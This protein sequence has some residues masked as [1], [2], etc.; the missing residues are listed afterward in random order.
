MTALSLTVPGRPLPYAR[1]RVDPRSGRHVIPK[2]QRAY[3]AHVESCMR[4]AMLQARQREP[5]MGALVMRLNVYVADLNCGDA[6]NLA[7]LQEDVAQKAGVF[8]DDVQIVDLI[9][10]R[11]V[12][13]KRPR[14]EVHV[15]QLGPIEDERI[16]PSKR[17]AT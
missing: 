14:V 12:D 15:E 2:A 8:V 6:S 4:A 17:R 13:R 7:K 9:I 16:P 5:M 11:H 3:R 1:T 10:H